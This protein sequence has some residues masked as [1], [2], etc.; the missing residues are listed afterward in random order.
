MHELHELNAA[1]ACF[2]SCNLCNSYNSCFKNS[3]Y[4]IS[5]TKINDQKSETTRYQERSY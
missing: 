4:C 3:W 1:L 5:S 2:N